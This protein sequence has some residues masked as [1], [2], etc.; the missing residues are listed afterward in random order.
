MP[1]KIRQICGCDICIILKDV[2]IGFYIFRTRLVTYLQQKYVV[3]HTRNSIFITRID[4]HYKYIVLP[5]GKCLCGTI[6]D[7]AQYITF[8]NIKLKN[9]VHIKCNLVFCGE[10]PEY[11][12]P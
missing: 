7:A 10:C 3:R 12:I 8:L 2:Q 11:N 1:P 6:K 5:D 4:A 9:M